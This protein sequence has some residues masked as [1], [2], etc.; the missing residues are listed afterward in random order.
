MIQANK[1]DWEVNNH[2]VVGGKVADDSQVWHDYRLE[3]LIE[4]NSHYLVYITARTW[5]ITMPDRVQYAN[6]GKLN[7]TTPS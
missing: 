3:H 7:R 2:K 6:S 4:C 1:T 5:D